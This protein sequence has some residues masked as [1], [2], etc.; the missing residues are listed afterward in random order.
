M[1]KIILYIFLIATVSFMACDIDR[2]PY[3]SMPDERIKSDPDASLVTLLNGA[4]AQLKG[5]SDV[6][7]RCGE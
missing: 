7:H 4:Y 2:L 5:W 6:M 3:S 1:K